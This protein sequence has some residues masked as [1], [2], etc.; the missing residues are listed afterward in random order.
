MD[1]AR[2]E[3]VDFFLGVLQQLNVP[4]DHRCKYQIVGRQTGVNQH[5]PQ[6]GEVIMLDGYWHKHYA[7]ELS[8]GLDGDWLKN[9]CTF[10]PEP[11]SSPVVCWYT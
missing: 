2:R 3:A 7:T 5:P 9:T 1:R 10:F 4:W 6:K 8:L 11:G